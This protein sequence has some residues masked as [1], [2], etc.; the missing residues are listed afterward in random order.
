M[1]TSSGVD[2]ISNLPV[3]LLVL[4]LKYT[5]PKGFFKALK[6]SRSWREILLS[7]NSEH[8]RKTFNQLMKE[9]CYWVWPTQ[10]CTAN[11]KFLET[12]QGYR[13]MLEFR[14][15]IRFDGIYMCKLIYYRKGLSEVS[16]RNPIHEVVSYRYIR[17]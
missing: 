15:K 10:V 2:C 17:F 7:A 4:L 12:F 14:P 3:E 8:R 1:K 5:G 9:Y 6:L 16:E 13:H 11:R